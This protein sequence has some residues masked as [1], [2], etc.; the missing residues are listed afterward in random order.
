MKILALA[1][2]CIGIGF[3]MRSLIQDQAVTAAPI[4]ESMPER[5][6]LSSYGPALQG[7][8]F[9]LDTANGRMWHA[10]KSRATALGTLAQ[11]K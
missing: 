10:D 4:G 9:I 5:Y 11:H 1:I 8:C 7:G 2:I 3:G 6:A